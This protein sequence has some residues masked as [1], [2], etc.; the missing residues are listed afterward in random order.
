MNAAES[1]QRHQAGIREQDETQMK[2]LLDATD[3]I[4]NAVNQTRDIIQDVA[5]LAERAEAP[6]LISSSIIQ[7]PLSTTFILI[8]HSIVPSSAL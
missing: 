1:A 6:N 7:V 2:A 4:M 3:A 5:L 8:V